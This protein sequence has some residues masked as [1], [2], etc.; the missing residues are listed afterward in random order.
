MAGA[1]SVDRFYIILAIAAALFLFPDE[2]WAVAYVLG[3]PY[4]VWVL[5][6]SLRES[7]LWVFGSRSTRLL[8][9]LRWIEIYGASWLTRGRRRKL[10]ERLIAHYQLDPGLEAIACLDSRSNGFIALEAM[11]EDVNRINRWSSH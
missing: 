6:F 10:A 11:M 9:R 7:L 3:L 8:G 5:L 2:T 4:A 1:R